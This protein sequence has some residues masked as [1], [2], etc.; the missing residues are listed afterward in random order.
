MLH[1]DF[2]LL[3][4]NT[5]GIDEQAKFFFSFSDKQELAAFLKNEFRKD[6]PY[7]VLGGGSNVLLTKPFAGTVIHPENK[8]ISV[9]EEQGNDVLVSVAAGEVWDDFVQWAVSNNLHGVENLS[10]IPGCVGAS[11]VQNIG[12][13][14]SEAKDAIYRVVCMAIGDQEERIFSN[15]ECRFGYRDSVFKHEEAGKYIVTDVVFKLHKNAPFNLGYG[16]LRNSIDE[17]TATLQIVRDT[18]IAIRKE[19]LPDPKEIGS[20]GS[21]FKNPVVPTEQAEQ[22]KQSFPDMVTYPAPDGKT[23]IAAGWLIDS[24][25]LKGFRIGG[26]QVHP[27]QALVLTNTGG[28]TATDVTNLASHVKTK[29]GETYGLTIEPEVIYL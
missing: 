7:F 28:A 13:Y 4:Y 16:S 10:F 15:E 29:V 26:A 6:L 19:K 2:S 22:L 14:G 5:F 23:K 24:L 3:Q 25:G 8:G 1:S 11:P 9:V 12:A 27:K 20:A 18:I 17:S 21:F